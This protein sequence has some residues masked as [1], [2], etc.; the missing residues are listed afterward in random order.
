MKVAIVT[1][2]SK[3][4]GRA[5][6]GGLAERGWSLVIDARGAEALKS[7]EDELRSSTL[8]GSAIVAIAGDIA[9]P[10][11][12][13]ELVEAARRLGGL[14]LL[15]N[16]ASTLGQR[17]LPKLVDYELD[18]FRDVFEVDVVAPLAL[19]QEAIGLLEHSD[20]PRAREHHV[21]RV[22]RAL[23]G[24]G[25]LRAR[26]GCARPPERERLQPRTRTSARGPSIPETSAPTCT[27]R[28]FPERTSRTGHFPDRSSRDFSL[29]SKATCRADAT[30]RAT[31][32][33]KRSERGGKTMSATIS[34]DP[35]VRSTR[36]AVVRVAARAR[37]VRSAR[38]T[39]DHPRC[40][41]DARR[42]PLRREPRPHLLLGAPAHSWTR[43]TWWW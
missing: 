37:G 25:R 15:V 21:G 6:A 29:S 26:E 16:N 14:D 13:H 20:S 11:H 10:A 38:S 2:A 31:S 22:D 18:S 7:A 3:G 23:R 32:R 30:R 5:L 42:H 40:G 28:R 43:A 8:Q 1:G 24:M 12:R 19:I 41:A 35:A 39:R 17:P 34:S 36:S 33:W 4:L 27:S 9:S